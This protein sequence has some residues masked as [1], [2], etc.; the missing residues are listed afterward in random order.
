[1]CD[2][3]DIPCDE[4]NLI[5]KAAHAMEAYLPDDLSAHF[6]L[7]KRIPIAAGLGGGSS[8]AA[9]ILKWLNVTAKLSQEKLKKIAVELG[10]DVPFFLQGGTAYAEGIG[11][12]LTPLEI[13]K[14]WWAVLVF[15]EFAV[16]TLWAYEQLKFSLTDK[17]KKA[18]I[19]S[20][21]EKGFNW[22]IFEND[23]DKAIIPSYPEIGKIKTRLYSLGVK[24]AGL[25][26]SGSTV[27][28]ICESCETAKRVVAAFN[29]AVIT[30]P[31]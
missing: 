25:S 1:V 4:K 2:H 12:I 30:R 24:Y 23:F 3:P 18:K 26:G 7:K 15:P 17:L 9:S 16:S 19:P 29:N 8:N 21:L 13:P 14:N 11:D 31:I 6:E 20:Q 27:F 5:I 28:G 10:A 22:Q